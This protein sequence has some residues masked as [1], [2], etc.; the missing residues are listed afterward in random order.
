MTKYGK[1][2]RNNATHVFHELRE[3]HSPNPW[4][5][6]KLTHYLRKWGTTPQLAKFSVFGHFLWAKEST[7][8]FITVL[9]LQFWIVEC[10]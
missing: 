5:P 8:K 10:E 6:P 3:K 4:W 2:Y 7:L 1:Y 9:S